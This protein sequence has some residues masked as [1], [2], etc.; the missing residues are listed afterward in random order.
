MLRIS[1]NVASLAAQRAFHQTERQTDRALREL[2]TGT[3]FT[4]P[5]GDPAGMAISEGLNAQVRGY[6]A[7][8]KNT[9]NASSFVA[10]AEGALAEQNN[11]IIRLREL[12]VQA[13]SDT[14]S[15]TERGYLN[16]EFTQLVE[17][18]DRIAHSTRYGSQ[19]LLDGSTRE[20]EFQVGVN[21]GDENV[22]TYTNDTDTTARNLDLKGL[23]VDDKGDARDALEDIDSA[24]QQV[25]AAR[26]KLG[27]VQS[28]MD[29]T[30]SHLQTQVENISGAYSKMSDVDVPE[31]VSKVRR[32]QILAQYQ[33]VALRAANDQI[34]NSLRL[35]A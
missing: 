19:P 14:L 27:A 22:I 9:E 3:R 32:G 26:A 29:T 8:L 13:A 10:I 6:Q 25:N 12:A 24:L 15:D 11:I 1:T 30:V 20:Y 23:A 18:F 21:K 35:I 2:A 7:A 4:S 5:G 31:A 16:V 34:E 17:E 28:R 33:A